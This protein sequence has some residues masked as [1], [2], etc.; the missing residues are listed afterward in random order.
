M[1]A[2]NIL[3]SEFTGMSTLA[4]LTEYLQFRKMSLSQLSL[5]GKKNTLNSLIK[6]L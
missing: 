4:T 6:I 3:L 1:K 5:V 2:L